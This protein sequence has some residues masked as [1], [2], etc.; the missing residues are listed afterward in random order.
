MT[1]INIKIR[2]YQ[3]D[4]ARDLVDI[5]Y[6]TI[7]KI[8]IQDYTKKQVDAWAPES[9]LKVDGR[10]KKWEKLKPLVAI[11][12]DTI[13]GFTEFDEKTGYIDCFYVH[14]DYIGKGVGTALMSRINDIAQNHK[15]RRIFAAVSITAKPF[16]EANGFKVIKEQI[17]DLQGIKLINSMMEKLNEQQTIEIRNLQEEDIAMIVD[18]FKQSRWTEKPKDIFLQYLSQQKNNSLLA[19][20]AF[21]QDKFA[22]YVT[23]KW[24][25]EY[26]DFYENNIPEISDLNVLPE[27]R[28]NGVATALIK[29]CEKQSL[30]RSKT[31]GIGFGLY[32]DYGNAQ[33]LYVKHGYVPDGKGV[34][35]KYKA[36]IPGEKY[37]VDDDLILWFVKKLG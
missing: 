5:Y 20:V 33:R 35:Y 13:V 30:T 6:N 37:P 31:I 18:S 27:F 4:D 7:H 14:H 12:G 2:N 17:I 28:K 9:S 8:N 15:V 34:T 32:D 29:E 3:P 21:L 22:G 26:K 23:L 16:F 1:N 19:Y 24:H 10:M 11:I 25:S 36:V